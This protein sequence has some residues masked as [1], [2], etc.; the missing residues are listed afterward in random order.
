MLNEPQ[1]EAPASCTTVRTLEEA[2]GA[3][4]HF[5]TRCIRV[6]AK[7]SDY[8][9]T[10]GPRLGTR[11]FFLKALSRLRPPGARHM[12]PSIR[13]PALLHPVRVRMLPSSDEFVVDQVFVEQGYTP[14]RNLDRPGFILDLGANVGYA[15]AL[16]ASMYPSARILAVEPD[17]A[18]FGLCVE[19]LKP[20]GS[21]VRVLHGAVWAR[22]TR[23]A[24]S[25]GLAG[26][27]RDWAVQVYESPRQQE[28]SVEA[29]DMASLLE[30]CGDP[31]IDLAKIDIEGSEAEIFSADTS[32]LSRVRNLCIELHG[33]G[34][35]EIFF[36]ALRGYDYERVDYGE[37]TILLNIRRRA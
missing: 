2:P 21:R 31:V 30:L 13:P 37:N 26:D 29:W 24:L 25:R 11:W 36:R 16:F 17:P 22:R 1:I 18:N 7:F 15:S 6:P 28:A 34:C 20:Y 19:N 35:R 33:D 8:W 3:R 9:R 5:V 14:L 10:L 12:A 27:G 32:W 4:P 23:L